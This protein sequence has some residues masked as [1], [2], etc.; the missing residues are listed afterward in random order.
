LSRALIQIVAPHAGEHRRGGQR[1]AEGV[2]D[3]PLCSAGLSTAADVARDE[4]RRSGQAVF[5]AMPVVLNELRE[6]VMARLG[7][8]S[9]LRANRGLFLIAG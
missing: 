7:L 2:E 6:A 8:R 4:G 9:M 1:G 3:L 5:S